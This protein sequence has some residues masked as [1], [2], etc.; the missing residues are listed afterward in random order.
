MSF[1]VLRGDC[2]EVMAAME[3]ASVD[4]VVTDPPYGLEFMGKEWDRLDG[5]LP[6][7]AVWKGRRGNGGS[8]IGTDDTKPSSRHRV[9]LGAGKK[10]AFKRCSTCGKRQFSGSPCVCSE[11]EWTI[12]YPEGAPS[13]SLRMQRWHETW[14]RE[15][16][17]VLKPGGHLLAFSGTRT[18]HRMVCAIED[19]GFEIRDSI[20]W[21]YGSGFPKSLDVSK[22]ID[23]AACAERDV[24]GVYASPEGTSGRSDGSGVECMAGKGIGGLNAITAPATPEAERWQGW[25]TALKPAHEPIVVARKP[26]VGTVAANVLT[27]GTGALNVDGCRVGF[28]GDAD[29][30]ESKAKNRHA[31]FGSGP[32]DNAV[33]GQDKRDRGTYDP[34]GR[35]PANVVLDG[36]A[37]A[38][39]DEQTGDR[40]SRA[41]TTKRQGLGYHGGST[42]ADGIGYG[43]DSGGASRFFYCA[44]TSTAERNAG[45]D[46]FP[47]GE[48]KKLDGGAWRSNVDE[49]NPAGTSSTADRVARNVHPT[50]KP[51]AL[52]RWL[53]RLVTPPGG[54]VLDPFLG[55]GTTGCAAALEG[56]EF[57]GIE[58]DEE[59]AAIAEAR[60]AFWAAQPPGLPLE[61]VLQREAA[62]VERATGRQ[63]GLF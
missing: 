36:E 15:A 32:R 63:D 35:W 56:F 5:G 20:V 26:L 27:H 19:A 11:P 53:V 10:H 41:G 6:Q 51:I 44:K 39:L 31:D 4:A 49:R 52:M 28:A 23:K 14:A 21:M 50:V 59:Y 40:P 47:M 2:V 34:P 8:S 60:V 29:E 57:V 25:G 1:R 55:S 42:D 18:S 33:F 38:M 22:A 9:S 13:S 3:P 61:R 54:L 37:A 17:R 62:R 48:S 46:R 30:T 43:D 45:L 24:V 58:R 7:E 12:E 16:L